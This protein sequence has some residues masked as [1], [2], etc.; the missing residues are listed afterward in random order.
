MAASRA[1]IVD[2]E[3]D[4]MPASPSRALTAPS[5]MTPSPDSVGS[6]S[7]RATTPPHSFW[8][9]RARRSMLALAMGRPSSVNPSAPAS[10]SS[11]ISVSDWPCWP[12]V[13]AA[14]KPTGTRA[15]TLARSAT[16]RSTEALSIG[17]DVFGMP[18]IAQNPP[19]AAA[20]VPVSMS[21]LCSWPGTRRCTCGSTNAGSR[22]VPPASTVSTPSGASSLSPSSAISPPR[23]STS[24]RRSRSVRGSSTWAPVT[25]R[26]AG[27]AG[28]RFSGGGLTRAAAPGVG[29]RASGLASRAALRRAARRGRPCAPPRRPAPGR[30]SPPAASR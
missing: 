4:G 25:S 16:E 28:M 11:A 19:A 2:S 24:M 23:T 10:R 29:R 9:C 17:G 20:R 13:A 12:A 22:W 21:S 1:I 30:R 8:Y 18:M 5:C 14:R 3:I 7:C 15:W 6:S 26:S 27:A